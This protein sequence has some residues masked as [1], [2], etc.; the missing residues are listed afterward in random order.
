MR[1]LKLAEQRGELL[2][3]IVSRVGPSRAFIT[4]GALEGFVSRHDVPEEKAVD[5]RKVLR[6]GMTVQVRILTLDD[7]GKAIALT[8]KHSG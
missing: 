7:A 4:L 6:R 3:G 5:L 2:T 1:R 8:M